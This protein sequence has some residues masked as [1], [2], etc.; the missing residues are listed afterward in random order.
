LL[1]ANNI[2]F[3]VTLN[4]IL[5]QTLILVIRLILSRAPVK[6]DEHLFHVSFYNKQSN[7][8]VM[9]LD[10]DGNTIRIP[11]SEHEFYYDLDKS[12]AFTVSKYKESNGQ[13]RKVVRGNVLLNDEELILE[14]YSDYAY[15]ETAEN[16]EGDE[17]GSDEKDSAEDPDDP[18]MINIPGDPIDKR[19]SSSADHLS[20]VYKRTLV[21]AH[22][23]ANDY[24]QKALDLSD[25]ETISKRQTSGAV[26]NFVQ[27][28]V[29]ADLGFFLT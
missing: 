18:L 28:L 4:L 9:V 1:N 5:K 13:V 6:I 21:H 24:I 27:L 7:V 19:R 22:A 11:E 2:I 23:N 17:G 20:K 14:P 10:A 3:N 29:V 8:P 12:A 15:E 16:S 26:N 25:A